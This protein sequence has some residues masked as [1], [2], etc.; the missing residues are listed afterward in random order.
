M[1]AP[2]L[3]AVAVAVFGAASYSNEPH[4]RARDLVIAIDSDRIQGTRGPDYPTLSFFRGIPYAAPPVGELRWRAP[5][6]PAHWTGIRRAEELSAACPQ[7]DD[8][9]TVRRDQMERLGGDPS[10]ARP[11]DKISED[12][13]YLNVITPR[14]GSAEGHPLPVIFYIHGGGGVM[15]RGDDDGAALAATG[16]AVVVTFNYRLGVLGWLAH[17]ALTAESER[18]LSGNYGLLDQLAAL[19][20]V[21]R[22]IAQFGGDPNNITIWGFSSGSQYVGCMMVS[23][24]ARG[25]FQRAIL[26]SG[27]PFDPKPRLQ[28]SFGQLP[29]AEESGVKLASSLGIDDGPGA[30]AKLRSLPVEKLLAQRVPYD[31]IVD[32]WAIPDQPLAIFGR[33]EQADVPVMVGSTERE[34]GSLMALLPPHPGADIY[35]EWMKDHLGPVVAEGLRLYPPP[36][37]GDASDVII[38]AADDIGSAAGARWLAQAMLKKKSKAYLYHSNWVF[39]TPGGREWGAF[40]GSDLVLMVEQAGIPIPKNGEELARAMRDYWT[41][42]AAT[43]NPNSP[44]R[45]NWPAC[46]TDGAY[47]LLGEPPHASRSLKQ[48]AFELINQANSYRL[49]AM[50]S[51]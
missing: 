25:L 30:L 14:S 38:R 10:K 51:Q 4:A 22:N 45:P 9:F 11:M 47:M 1:K 29:S 7:S 28:Q 39:D 33:G 35:I 23:P 20:W 21:R 2:A 44:Q 8:M 15:G 18:H 6:L 26:Q 48:P 34:M 41:H 17:P 37:S 43:G 5:Q 46:D 49:S 24:L 13:L 16:A 32:K 31:I 50:A 19:R 40:H 42:F 27:L 12:C 36:D 3:I